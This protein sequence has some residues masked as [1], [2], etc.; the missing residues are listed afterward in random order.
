MKSARIQINDDGQI[1]R[2][3]DVPARPDALKLHIT[4]PN[5]PPFEMVLRTGAVSVGRADECALRLPDPKV[6]RRH[7][8]LLCLD[9]D[10]TV[11]DCGSQN[12]TFLNGARLRGPRRVRPGDILRMGH[13]SLFVT[14]A[15]TTS[16]A[17]AICLEPASGKV[18]ET[19]RHDAPL[20]AGP[21]ALC[22]ETEVLERPPG[23]WAAAATDEAERRGCDEGVR[24]RESTRPRLRS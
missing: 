1:E 16:T 11:L 19:S 13:T 20:H 7:A 2:S 6:S 8:E 9:G 10:W 3:D 24:R 18:D 17:P 23:G 4:P 12:G 22:G 21:S 15:L 5:R 14:H